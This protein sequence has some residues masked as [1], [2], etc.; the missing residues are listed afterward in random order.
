MSRCGLHNL[1]NNE[2]GFCPECETDPRLI[3]LTCKT[4]GK[5]FASNQEGVVD[6]KIANWPENCGRC[7][8]KRM[9]EFFK[10]LKS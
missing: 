2:Q 6:P 3:I 4:C 8:L 10:N 9:E 7:D 5:P 1:T